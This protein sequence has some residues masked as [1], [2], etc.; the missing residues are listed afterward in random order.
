MQFMTF[1]VHQLIQSLKHLKALKENEAK[2]NTVL[3]CQ[4]TVKYKSVSCENDSE[5]KKWC[6]IVTVASH[7]IIKVFDDPV[8]HLMQPQFLP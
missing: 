8:I 6:I 1:L 4:V 7:I 5:K 3:S 2:A